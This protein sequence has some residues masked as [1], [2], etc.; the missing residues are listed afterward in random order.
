MCLWNFSCGWP[1]SSLL[2]LPSQ[3]AGAVTHACESEP[4]KQATEVMI[5]HKELTKTMLTCTPIAE[6]SFKAMLA[7][8]ICKVQTHM[9]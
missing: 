2:R 1:V 6:G 7:H 5:T 9:R 4:I 3:D 8:C